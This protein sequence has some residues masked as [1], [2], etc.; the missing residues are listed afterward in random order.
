MLLSDRY[1]GA[2]PIIPEAHA[3]PTAKVSGLVEQTERI[4]TYSDVIDIL[5]SES[6]K[7]SSELKTLVRRS[8]LI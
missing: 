2:D 8:T 4:W 5:L 1:I 3:R 6:V 7:L